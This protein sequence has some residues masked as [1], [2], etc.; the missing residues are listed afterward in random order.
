M[1]KPID[2]DLFV[3][4]WSISEAPVTLRNKILRLVNTD[5]YL[6]AYQG[7][8]SGVDNVKYFADFAKKKSD[9]TW[10]TEKI[11]HL[12]DSYYLIGER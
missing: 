3:S 12:K 5:R 8:F 11:E 9:F 6:F 2:V 4:L 1:S 10:R 7:G